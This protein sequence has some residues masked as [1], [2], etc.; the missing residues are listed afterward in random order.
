MVLYVAAIGVAMIARRQEKLCWARSYKK[1]PCHD[2]DEDAKVS[3]TYANGI[4]FEDDLR[5]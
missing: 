1:L 2:D 5:S 3:M 4:D